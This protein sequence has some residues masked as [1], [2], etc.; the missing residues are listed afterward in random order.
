MESSLVFWDYA[1]IA[2]Y[3]IFALG[4][5]VI[6]SKKASKSTESYFLGN[7]SLP[8][9]M[10]GISMVA[11]SFASD[12]PLV[13]TEIVRKYGVQRLWWVF[14]A[15]L[16]LVVGIFLFSRLWRRAEI[17]TDAEFYELRYHGNSAAFLRAY[18]AFFAGIIQNL[19]T[20]GWVTFAMSTI[21]TTMTSMDKWW[22]I[23]VCMI[24]ALIYSTFSGFYGVVITDLVQFFIATF[25]MTALA[26]I[27]VAKMG[28]L[29][30]LFQKIAATPGFSEKTLNLFPDFTTFD[31]DVVALIIFVFVIWWS[32]A[33]GYNMQRMSACK[34]ERHAILA[35]IFYAI[36]Q[37]TRP[38]M[39]VGVAL[40]SIVLFPDL[41]GENYTNTET[42]AMVMNTFLGPGMKGLLIT[43]FLAAFMSTIDTH[44]NWGASYL[45]TDVY[46]RFYKKDASQR[47]YVMVTK[48]IVVVLMFAGA[49]LVPFMESI[50]GAWVFLA[51]IMA[52]SGMIH[53]ARWFW[54]RINA[55][56]EI[57]ALT[58]G[59]IGGILHLF[60]PD[61]VVLFGFPWSELPFE[62]KIALYTGIIVPI[63]IA[64]TYMTPRV[65]V[66]KLDA[67]Y[68][69]VRPGGFW[70]V[71]S[72]ETL[73][74][75]GKAV[76]K[77]TL[78]DI[79]AGIC[80]CFGI[81]LGVG[82]AILLQPSKSA[83]CLS[84]ALIGGIRMYFWYQKE[85]KELEL[86]KG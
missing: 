77:T 56:T 8:W 72:K 49:C 73:A 6:F 30:A 14:V 81:S 54:W 47:H 78:M 86:N 21:I 1:I 24:V 42:Y 16:M 18:R 17:V 82:Y 40:V 27:A 12:T 36:F 84:L 11:T 68:R 67:F 50:E 23:G 15:V 46:Q 64:V 65:P 31:M 71:L 28:G 41:S 51:L 7:R 69:K 3:M 20:I 83:F 10:I 37:T 33:N 53:F 79:A 66:E 32:D 85:V 58:L 9:W 52:G 63:S 19:I 25:S 80:L 55:Y 60:L 34:N 76:N 61:S 75:P 48:I 13:I 62:I 4:I 44:L 70:G 22:A 29:E 38:W 74:L 57:T 43:A 45:M 59:L 26:V 35:T 2:S 5:G 39:W